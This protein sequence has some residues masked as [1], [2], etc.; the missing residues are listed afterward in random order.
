MT[1]VTANNKKMTFKEIRDR[2]QTRFQVK[3]TPGLYV[4][5]RDSCYFYFRYTDVSGKRRELPLLTFS[6]DTTQN[7]GISLL[8]QAISLAEDYAKICREGRDPIEYA[9]ECKRKNVHATLNKINPPTIITFK[10]CAE[11]W[12]RER[13]E[14]NFWRNNARGEAEARSKLRNHIYPSLGEKDIQ[15]IDAQDVLTCLAPIWQSKPSVADKVKTIVKQ[16]M[17]WAIAYKKRTNENNPASLDG[18]L[19]VFLE[20]FKNDRVEEKHYAACPYEEIPLLMKTLH[21]YSS[22]SAKIFEF[23]ILTAVRPK[24]VRLMKWDGELDLERG[25]WVVPRENDKAK[26]ISRDRTIYLSSYA[27]KLLKNLIRFSSPYVF[28]SSQGN[29]FSEDAIRMFITGIHKKKFDKDGIGWV[30]P[31]ITDKNGKPKIITP[32]GTARASFKTWSKS[33]ENQDL[34]Q[35]AVE[36]CML[37]GKNDPYKG[38]YDR[39]TL[40]EQSREIMERWGKY[41]YSLIDTEKNI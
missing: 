37:H 5:K 26:A 24:A 14:R 12:V 27:I 23:Q 2:Q 39:N 1:K 33:V 36:R 29:H 34:N 32:H 20:S 9:R 40:E 17:Q 3:G 25:I 11:D 21:Q 28:V 30:D 4:C 31:S 16:V 10:Q 22:M 19:G 13:V 8:R 41:C 38:A 15:K 35:D 6:H 7:K 18:S